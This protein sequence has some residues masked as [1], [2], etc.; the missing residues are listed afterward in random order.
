MT[1]R[2]RAALAE[3]VRLVSLLL[4]VLAMLFLAV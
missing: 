2:L 1:P 3:A 4:A